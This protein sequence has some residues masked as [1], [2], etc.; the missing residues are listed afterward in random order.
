MDLANAQLS[1]FQ[2]HPFISHG[3]D[4]LTR[5]IVTSKHQEILHAGP[6]LMMANLKR[7]TR[8]ICKQC[9]VCRKAAARTSQQSMGQL[10]SSRI[11]LGRVF[12]NVG[13]DYAGPVITERGHT[14]RPILQ[15]T[16]ICVFVCMAVK[17]VN[18]EAVSDLTSSKD[19]FIEEGSQVKFYLTM[20]HLKCSQQ[21]W[22]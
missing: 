3:K 15:K 2:K 14:R 12:S 5:L 10:P 13:I 7:L 8:T 1:A 22:H 9:V 11:T 20:D 19:S 17:A 18:L 4:V 16:Y 21:C 6:T